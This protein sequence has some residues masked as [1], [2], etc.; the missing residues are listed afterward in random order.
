MNILY[1]EIGSFLALFE[2]EFYDVIDFVEISDSERSWVSWICIL[3]FN[4]YIFY[5]SLMSEEWTTKKID[6]Y[7]VVNKKLGSGTYGIVYRGF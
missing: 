7:V 5:H 1:W 4:Q 6:K 3:Y 2:L